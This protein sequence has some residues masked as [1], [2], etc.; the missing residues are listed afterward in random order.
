MA[1]ADGWVCRACWKPNRQRDERCY[2]CKVPRRADEAVIEVERKARKAATE[3]PLAEPVP[4]W[5]VALPAVVFAWTGILWRRASIFIAVTSVL[6]VL[7]GVPEQAAAILALAAV[8]YAIGAGFGAISNGMRS[9]GVW[10][11]FAGFVAAGVPTALTIWALFAL[12]TTAAP[13]WLPAWFTTLA[14]ASTIAGWVTFVLN[15]LAAVCALVGLILALM[16]PAPQAVRGAP[17]PHS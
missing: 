13:G 3:R 6:A 9:R 14:T 2:V 12:S 17:Q 11:F 15:G 1:F 4:D 7:G 16:R 10:A 5:L 8:Y